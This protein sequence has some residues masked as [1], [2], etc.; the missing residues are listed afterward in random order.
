MFVLLQPGLSIR[1]MYLLWWMLAGLVSDN[2]SPNASKVVKMVNS[3]A[4]VQSNG[5]SGMPILWS[6]LY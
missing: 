1:F 3:L 6:V 2:T 4:G 5:F